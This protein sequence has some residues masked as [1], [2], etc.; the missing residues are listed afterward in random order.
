MGSSRSVLGGGSGE[1]L[2]D[3]H[4][5]LLLES[6]SAIMDTLHPGKDGDSLTL[7]NINQFLST[8]LTLTKANSMDTSFAPEGIETLT[9]MQSQLSAVDQ[10]SDQTVSYPMFR[11]WY[12]FTRRYVQVSPVHHKANLYSHSTESQGS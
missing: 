7:T 12:Q 2:N 11:M 9:A 1:T 3:D 8:A 6:Y 10:T 4:E 5:K